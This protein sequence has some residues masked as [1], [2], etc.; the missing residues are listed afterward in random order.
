ME[1]RPF[2]PFV[3]PRAFAYASVLGWNPDE[4]QN[5]VYFDATRVLIRSLQD[6]AADFVV[7]M[8]YHDV[9][10]E[11]LLRTEGAI[12]KHISPIYH[13]LGVTYFEPWFVDI[14]LAKLRAF[15]LTEYKRVQLL[16]V[17]TYIDGSYQLDTL[18]NSFPDS[19]IVAE[20]LG[21]DS[22]LRAGWLMLKP[23]S[24]DFNEMQQLLE[25]GVFTSELG[26]DNLGLPVQ[27]PGWL[28]PTSGSWEFYGSQLEQSKSRL[29]LFF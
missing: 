3:V 14:A 6:S 23:S 10:T 29:C 17:D 16:D 2:P 13:S 1:Q 25:L 27:Y 15:E 9:E 28:Y 18:F 21:A 24:E 20:G 11:T 22:P 7:L 19:K 5:S 26:W 12:V 8:M 4:S